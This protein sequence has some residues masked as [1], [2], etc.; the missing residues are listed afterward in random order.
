M[1][2]PIWKANF[3][4]DAAK[5]PEYRFL[6]IEP[7][8]SYGIA[9]GLLLFVVAFFIKHGKLQTTGLAILSATAL[10]FIP[11]MSARRSALP[12]IEQIYRLD[13]SERGKLFLENTILWSASTWMYTALVILAV[14]TF[15]VGSR[16]NQLGYGLS[17]AITLV[18]LLAIQNSLWMHYQ[19]ASAV[20][21]NLRSHHAPIQTTRSTSEDRTSRRIPSP[22]TFEESSHAA[23]VNV[24][25]AIPKR[26]AV[27]PIQ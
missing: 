17:V 2:D 20:H 25:R 21:P 4:I 23:P 3:L 1:K 15:I 14:A 13:G 7:I 26:R 16:R 27:R 24:P 5:D 19:D 22:V 12:R 11:Y 18:G 6:L 8:L 10:C 9:F